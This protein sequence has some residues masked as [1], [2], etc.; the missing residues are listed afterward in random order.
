MA[1]DCVCGHGESLAPII[2]DSE[3]GTAV[4]AEIGMDFKTALPEIRSCWRQIR[5]RSVLV[6][7]TLKKQSCKLGFNFS[8]S[9]PSR[10]DKSR[11]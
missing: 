4:L 11:D 2:G 7:L 8:R 3:C 9:L 10:S 5:Q 6:I 1:L